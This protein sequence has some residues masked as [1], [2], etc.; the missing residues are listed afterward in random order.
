MI[1]SCSGVSKSYGTDTILEKVSFNI[2][3]K[4]VYKRQIQLSYA[5]ILIKST[6][7]YKLFAKICQHDFMI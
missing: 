7:Y 6:I 3:D 4:D 1:F 5:H 2:D